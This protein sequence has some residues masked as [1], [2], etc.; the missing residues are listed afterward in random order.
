[1]KVRAKFS[2]PGPGPDGEK[3]NLGV[4]TAMRAAAVK[5]F[6]DRDIAGKVD[7]W[8][9]AIQDKMLPL[10]RAQE[11]IEAAT[12]AAIPEGMNA[13][14]SEELMT[15]KIGARVGAAAQRNGGALDRRHEG[16]WRHAR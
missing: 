6:A 15:G 9:T 16:V 13:Y 11:R 8:R 7:D 12:G 14:L 1:V 10:L 3:P 5:L 4:I 2:I